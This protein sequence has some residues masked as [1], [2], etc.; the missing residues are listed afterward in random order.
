MKKKFSSVDFGWL[1]FILVIG[2]ICYRNIQYYRTLK[3][4]RD[5]NPQ[6]IMA[7]R[8]YPRVVIPSGESVEFKLPDELI[9]NFFQSLTDIRSYWPNHDT[10]VSW[11]HEW[12]VEVMTRDITI[13]ISF[14]IPSRKDDIVAGEFGKWGESSDFFYGDFQSRKLFQW[15]QKYKDRWLSPPAATEEEGEKIRR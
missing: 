13:Q 11:D 5:I 1:L 9:T 7:F 2:I 8:I 6:D 12:F 4:L 15:Y 14:H 10:V 3:I